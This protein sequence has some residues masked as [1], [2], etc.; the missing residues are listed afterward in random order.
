MIFCFKLH[1]A[2]GE[3]RNKWSILATFSHVDNKKTF[4]YPWFYVAF[5]Y[6]RVRTYSIA[7]G[8]PKCLNTLFQWFSSLTAL[9]ACIFSPSDYGLTILNERTLRVTGVTF[10][11]RPME[12]RI[13]YSALKEVV[14]NKF[15][16]TWWL[17][18]DDKWHASL[19]RIPFSRCE[20]RTPRFYLRCQS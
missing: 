17:G 9:A 5:V 2:S 4:H 13:L 8:R 15:R 7:T 14:R 19:N 3:V 1:T 18:T 20:S 12:F 11:L 10:I 16:Q 6:T